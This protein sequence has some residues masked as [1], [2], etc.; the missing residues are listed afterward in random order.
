MSKEELGR[1]RRF[2]DIVLGTRRGQGEGVRDVLEGHFS[3]YQLA[4]GF[5]EEF[6][7]SHSEEDEE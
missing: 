3:R 1:V 4:F 5:F 6:L 2:R 7:E